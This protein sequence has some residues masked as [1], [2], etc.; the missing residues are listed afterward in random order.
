VIVTFYAGQV[1]AEP[2]SIPY[3]HSPLIPLQFLCSSFLTSMAVVMVLEAATDRVDRGGRVLAGGVF[4]GPRSWLDLGPSADGHRAAR[5]SARAC[6]SWT[7]GRDR[8]LF[9]G[10]VV[11]VGT[12]LPLLLGLIAAV[13]SGT[14]DALAWVLLI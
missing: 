3:W 7:R 1:L 9:L 4:R 12:A 14:R 8:I 11:A 10:G 5:A 2:K 13:A 6:S